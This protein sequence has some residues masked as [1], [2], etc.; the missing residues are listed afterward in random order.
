LFSEPLD[1]LGRGIITV[2]IILLMFNSMLRYWHLFREK[3]NSTNQT[4]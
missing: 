4:Q 3:I 2:V 1:F